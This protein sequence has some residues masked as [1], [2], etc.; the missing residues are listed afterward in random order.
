MQPLS[1]AQS[2]PEP[3]VR[4][5]FIGGVSVCSHVVFMPVSAWLAVMSRIPSHADLPS[6]DVVLGCF[7]L[8]VYVQGW[9]LE[10]GWVNS[11]L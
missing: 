7:T 5:E 9:V 3:E 2:F 6:V 1:P 10:P 4:A 11:H 8:L